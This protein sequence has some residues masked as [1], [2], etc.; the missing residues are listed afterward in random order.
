MKVL[1]TGGTGLIGSHAA[2]ALTQAGHQ[3][4]V[5]GRDASKIEGVMSGCGVVVED[6]AVGDTRDATAVTNALQGCDAVLHAA[7]TIEI[8]RSKK[9]YDANVAGTYN[10]LGGAAELGLDPIVY[11]S[12]VTALFPH[13]HESVRV[14]DPVGNLETG[15][16]RSKAQSER[17]ARS[18]QARGIPIVTLYPGAVYG[19]YD[20]AFGLGSMGLCERIRS[21]WPMSGGGMSNVDVRDLAAIVAA[22]MQPHHGPRRFMAAGHYLTWRDEASLCERLI[23]KSVKRY[24]VPAPLLH[25]AGHIVDLI[26]RVVPGFSYPL[27]HEASLLMTESKPCDSRATV[28]TLGVEFR[29]C[30]QTYEDT[31][32]WL[33]SAGHLQ[34]RYAPR[35]AGVET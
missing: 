27:T 31:L 24:P 19:P 2:V 21:G 23:G 1:L 11:F 14:D 8:G 22:V 7:A 6:I 10:V 35:L 29:S 26:Q 4:R 3:L 32:R 5:F 28:E 30:E 34:V 33:V 16:G 18:L 9:I 17:Y 15:Y 25:A 13:H 12:S 20:P